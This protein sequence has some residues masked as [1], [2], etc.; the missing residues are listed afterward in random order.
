[1]VEKIIVEGVSSKQLSLRINHSTGSFQF[2]A[3]QTAV[4][5]VD[6]QVSQLGSQLNRITNTISETL[7]EAPLKQQ[8]SDARKA[9][10]G[11][12]LEASEDEYVSFLDRKALIERRKEGLERLQ[13]EKQKEERRVKDIEE[14][15]R[16]KEEDE[17]LQNEENVRNQEKKK[18]LQEKME[19]LRVQKELEK[20]GVVM[21][22]SAIADLDTTSRRALI[23]DAQSESVKAKEE[24]TRRIT[25][26]SRRL[27]HITRALRIEGAAAITQKYAAQLE[28][29]SK[30]HAVRT[31]EI[32]VELKAKHD[33]DV[34]EKDRLQKMQPHRS[35]FEASIVLK[36]RVLWER[37]R[38]QMRKLAL[39]AARDQNIARARRLFDEEMERLE[40]EEERERAILAKEESD[41]IE[42][43]REEKLRKQRELDEAAEREREA[44]S[45]RIKKQIAEAEAAKKAI[46]EEPVKAAYKPPSARTSAP[47][48]A[49]GGF[50]RFKRDEAP[51]ARKEGDNWRGSA[52]AA[53]SASGDRPA[54]SA[55]RWTSE[56][57]K[58]GDNT[59]KP[60]PQS[61]DKW[62]PSSGGSS[63]GPPPPKESTRARW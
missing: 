59:N 52:P 21:D 37:K 32:R 25:E 33:A 42:L 51:P 34:A 62:K 43:E 23:L 15:R 45:Q 40:E 44:T 46:A 41:R 13:H 39:I 47:A 28:E 60:P 53:S 16:K 17:R 31:E 18:K 49:S 50:D 30:Q 24:E 36:Q 58:A 56:R 55:G 12:V 11:R 19:L 29:D 4:S 63:S 1:L 57:E 14:A 38:T 35:A 9:F 6:V 2:G 61:G 10:L 48:P 54:P 3:P 26:Q 20:H 27:D 22:E 5:V 8:R 7:G